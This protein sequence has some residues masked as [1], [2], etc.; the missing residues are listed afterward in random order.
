MPANQRSFKLP[1][2]PSGWR[3]TPKGQIYYKTY[4]KTPLYKEKLKKHY[5][6]K[7]GTPEKDRRGQ[8]RRYGLTKTQYQNLF[9]TQNGVCAICSKATIKKLAVDH[10]HKTKIVRGLLCANCNIGLGHFK[11]DINLLAKAIGYL[12]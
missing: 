8:L 6:E 3:K 9:V 5:M 10:D 12:T 1:K 11:D 2:D 4:L 7:G